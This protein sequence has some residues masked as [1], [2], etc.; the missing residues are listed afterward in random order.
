MRPA[1]DAAMQWWAD[2]PN[3]P[4]NTVMYV[5]GFWP[6]DILISIEAIAVVPE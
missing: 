4:L 5:S 3:P 1:F 2:R 6:A